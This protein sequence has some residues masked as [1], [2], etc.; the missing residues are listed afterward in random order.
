MIL[1]INSY[2]LCIEVYGVFNIKSCREFRNAGLS[3]YGDNIDF[4][5]RLDHLDVR[6][7]NLDG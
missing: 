1:F 5:V 3:F 2:E 7:V 4:K 6:N